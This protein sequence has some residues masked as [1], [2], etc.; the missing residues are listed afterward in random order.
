MLPLLI[1]DGLL[2]VLYLFRLGGVLAGLGEV[3]ARI[4]SHATAGGHHVDQF[5]RRASLVSVFLVLQFLVTAGW[6]PFA[7]LLCGG[8]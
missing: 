1:A 7:Y 8:Q 5:I 3:M 2:V 4:I 6:L